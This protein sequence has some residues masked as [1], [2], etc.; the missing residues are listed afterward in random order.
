[1]TARSKK[2]DQVLGVTTVVE[3]TST[4]PKNGRAPVLPGGVRAK[5]GLFA[6]CWVFSYLTG[7][8]VARAEFF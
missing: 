6:F 8:V 5:V 1:M 4:F 7:W 3:H 2:R